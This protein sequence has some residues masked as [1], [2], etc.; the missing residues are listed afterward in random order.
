MLQ[1]SFQN[2]SDGNFFRTISYSYNSTLSVCIIESSTAYSTNLHIHISFLLIN[3]TY[4]EVSIS[5]PHEV[6][7]FYVFFCVIQLW[8][9][10]DVWYRS[11]ALTVFSNSYC[12]KPMFFYKQIS[13]NACLC[14]CRFIYR[15]TTW[16]YEDN[17]LT[18][19]RT[20]H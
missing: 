4:W 9:S 3:G 7:V 18:Y 2:A 15:H 1:E 20:S 12:V 11:R 14:H 13:F 17:I 5:L 19:G 16:V 10:V 8:W 6:S